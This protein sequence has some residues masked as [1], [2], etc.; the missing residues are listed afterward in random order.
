M[1]HLNRMQTEGN[2]FTLHLIFKLPRCT[3]VRG[4]YLHG[5]DAQVFHSSHAGNPNNVSW[6]AVAA[7]TETLLSFCLT[8]MRVHVPERSP[9]AFG[10][11]HP[12]LMSN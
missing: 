1:R 5:W 3:S 11:M 4:L 8:S 6:E 2:V 10:A 9:S 7:W 12:Q